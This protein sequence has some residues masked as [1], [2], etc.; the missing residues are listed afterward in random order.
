V[1]S[2]PFVFWKVG[3]EVE[4]M[5]VVRKTRLKLAIFEQFPSQ[6]AFLDS[7]ADSKNGVEITE[8]RLSRI[9]TGHLDPRPEE[10]RHIA[11]KLNKTIAEL[12]TGEDRK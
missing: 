8:F 4:A 2:R 10:M 1:I 7:L 9:I 11:W 12:F 5:P 3:Q 6:R